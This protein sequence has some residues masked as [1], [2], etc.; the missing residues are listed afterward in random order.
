VLPD[1]QWRRIRGCQ[2]S[3][4]KNFNGTT[5][6]EDRVDVGRRAVHSIT[7]LSRP[8]KSDGLPSCDWLTH[9]LLFELFGAFYITRPSLHRSRSLLGLPKDPKQTRGGG[10]F[11]IWRDSSEAKTRQFQYHVPVQP[12]VVGIASA[13][14]RAFTGAGKRQPY[15]SSL[16]PAA[17]GHSMQSQAA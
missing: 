6:L 7:C 11:M 12:R 17:S 14:D 16:S 8:R 4:L 2:C 1:V 5:A 10:R 15:K 13:S 3:E 9:A